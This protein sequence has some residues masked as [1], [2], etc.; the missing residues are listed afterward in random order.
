MEPEVNLYDVISLTLETKR[1]CEKFNLT[2][3]VT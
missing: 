1:P 2:V 3:T